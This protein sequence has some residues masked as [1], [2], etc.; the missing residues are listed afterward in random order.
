MPYNHA[1]QTFRFCPYCSVKLNRV[2]QWYDEDSE[3]FAVFR[4]DNDTFSCDRDRWFYW[5]TI[6]YNFHEVTNNVTR[7]RLIGKYGLGPEKKSGKG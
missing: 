4:C 1:K 3:W 6:T 5:D 7:G 2:D